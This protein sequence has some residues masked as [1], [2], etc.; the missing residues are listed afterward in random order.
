MGCDRCNKLIAA[1]RESVSL[2]RNA[3]WKVAGAQGSG[4]P[5]KR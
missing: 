2:F 4:Q 1:Y 3:V 5:F